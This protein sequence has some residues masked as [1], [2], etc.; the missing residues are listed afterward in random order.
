MLKYGPEIIAQEISRTL[1]EIADTGIYPD[2]ITEGI[3]V[4]LPKPGKPKGP[5]ENIR[6]IVL[7]TSIRKIM[8]IC[9]TKRIANRLDSHIPA[10]QAAYRHGRGTTEH[11]FALK[12]LAEKAITADSYE[13]HLLLLDMSKAF[14]SV[15]RVIL[16]EDLREILEEDELHLLAILLRDVQLQVRVGDVLGKS[17]KTNIGVPQGDCLSPILFTLYLAKALRQLDAETPSVPPSLQDHSYYQ[18]RP[19]QYRPA[20]LESHNYAIPSPVYFGVALQY[21]DDITWASNNINPITTVERKAPEA[22]ERRNLKVNASKTEKH[23]ISRNGSDEGWKKCKYLGSLLD[24]EQD[25]TRRKV[26][27]MA[28]FNKHRDIFNSGAISNKTKVKTFRAFV[29]PV[30]LYN[31]ELWTLTRSLEENIDA[32]QRRL[33]RSILGIKWPKKI[34]NADL[35]KKADEIPWS[36]AIAKR[37]LRWTGHLLRLPDVTPAKQALLEAIR[38]T[39]LPRGGQRT[40]WLKTIKRDLTSTE[41]N[42]YDPH[43]WD[44]ARDRDQWRTLTECAMSDALDACAR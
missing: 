9:L 8:A 40:T 17:F 10:S 21:A 34:T 29:A 43:T 13:L 27:S 36:V 31:S 28:S 3:L 32:F 44:L 11:V 35:Y 2:D 30:F 12:I 33:L 20:E 41:V 22:L 26:L 7:L 4:P 25:I 39:K 38:K 14:D 16:F 19:S 6:P 18:Q 23:H 15:K 1:N 42:I 5:P 37:R 24:T